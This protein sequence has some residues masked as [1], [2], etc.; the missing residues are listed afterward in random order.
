MPTTNSRAANLLDHEVRELRD[1]G[2][3]LVVRLVKPQPDIDITGAVP[4]RRG[5]YSFLRLPNGNEYGPFRCPF[6]APGQVLYGRE[7]WAALRFSHDHE[8]GICDDYTECSPIDVLDYLQDIHFYGTPQMHPRNGFVYRATGEWPTHKDDRGFSWRGASV[9][10][11]G[12][13]RPE[14]QRLVLRCAE[15]KRIEEVTVEHALRESLTKREPNP[16]VW[17][18]V[19]ESEGE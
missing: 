14:L 12:A 2:R 13:V 17:V 10:P 9:M 3:V 16:L 6:G 1:K 5:R 8:T 11:Y 15:L 7:A 19:V 4:E 18:A